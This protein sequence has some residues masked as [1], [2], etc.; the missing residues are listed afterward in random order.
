MIANIDPVASR[1][2]VTLADIE[3]LSAAFEDEGACLEEMIATLEAD[4]EAVKQKHMRPIK[5]QAAAVAQREAELHSAVESA[6]ELFKKPRTITVHGVKCGFT[7]SAG[8]LVWDD[9]DNVIALIRRYRKDDAELLIRTT[10]EP[11]KDALK[12]LPAGDLAKLGCRIE[13]AG[14]QVIV[15]RTAGDVEKLI[16]KLVE[17]MVEAMVEAS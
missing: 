15:K 14:D 17:K 10:E 2:L 12:S 3:R 13:G 9:P 5:R 11:N 7:L 4:L 8:K 6:P 16:N 1:K